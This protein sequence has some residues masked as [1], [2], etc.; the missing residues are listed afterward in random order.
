[1][2]RRG[3]QPEVQLTLL[4]WGGTLTGTTIGIIAIGAVVFIVLA[5]TVLLRDQGFELSVGGQRLHLKLTTPGR[6]EGRGAS[7]RSP[8]PAR[9]RRRRSARSVASLHDQAEPPASR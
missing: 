8:A 4:F 9:R 2:V 6:Q 7:G 5:V 1:M 3:P